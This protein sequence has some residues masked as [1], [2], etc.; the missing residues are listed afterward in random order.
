MTQK[1]LNNLLY[2]RIMKNEII[3]S[4]WSTININLR[5]LIHI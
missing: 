3:L 1:I 2:K 4:F 5:I